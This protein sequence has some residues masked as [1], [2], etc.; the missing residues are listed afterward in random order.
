MILEVAI[1]QVKDGMRDSFEQ[2]FKEASQYIDCQKGY[3]KHDLKRCVEDSNKYILL[4]EWENLVDHMEGFRNSD[5]Y[6]QWKKLLHHY[7]D[8]F[9]DVEHFEVL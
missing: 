4:V 6:R 2:G 3:I 5:E 8:P 9:P 1:L 7:Y